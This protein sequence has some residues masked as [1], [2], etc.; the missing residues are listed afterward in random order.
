MKV[1][2]VSETKSSFIP[3]EL[4]AINYSGIYSINNLF[5]S[6]LFFVIYIETV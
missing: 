2:R 6:F 5:K 4:F 3:K 1:V